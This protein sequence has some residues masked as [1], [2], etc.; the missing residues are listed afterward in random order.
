MMKEGVV[1]CAL[2]GLKEGVRSVLRMRGICPE[3]IK[4]GKV[5]SVFLLCELVV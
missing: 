3:C 4:G 2:N 1:E 5:D